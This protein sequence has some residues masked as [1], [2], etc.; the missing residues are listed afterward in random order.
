MSMKTAYLTHPDCLLH[1][2]GREHPES[3]DRLRA[4]ERHL[5]E[6]GV[7]PHLERHIAP[8]ATRRQLLR[9]HTEDYIDMV[10]SAPP[11]SGLV[12]LSFDAAMCP[13][14]LKAAL[15][16]AGAVTEAVD[17]VLFGD[18]DNAFCAIR[19]PGHHAESGFG[20]GFCIF[21]NVAVGAAHAMAEFGL[22]RVAILDF[23]VHHGNGTNEIFRRDER[24]L[25]CSTFQSPFYPYCGETSGNHHIINVPLPAET[26]SAAFRQAI[27]EHWIPAVEAFEPEMIFISAGF[28]AHRDDFMSNFLLTEAD[29]AWVTAEIMKLANKHAQG[30]VVSVLEGGYN[31]DSLGASVVAHVR[32][33]AGLATPEARTPRPKR[34]ITRELVDLLRLRYTLNWQ[35]M[36]GIAHWARVRRNGLR[37]AERTGARRDVV[38][39][40]AFL[41]D[42][43]RESD[44]DDPDHGRR[45]AELA[46]VLQGNFFLLDAAGLETL[47]LALMTHTHGEF[48]QDVTIQTCW[49]ANRLDLTRI[50]IQ[51]DPARLMTDAA[52]EI[53]LAGCATETIILQV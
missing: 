47:C 35:G 18:V 3:P 41:H 9:V 28:D 7:M 34:L 46:R 8:L 14:S 44:G 27:I 29:Y 17:R 38:E 49:D 37:L 43:C 48:T 22:K 5:A 21:N 1:T 31:A 45:A 6:S 39:L 26:D 13:D 16:A 10:E 15:R 25:L 11:E 23:D 53:A 36:H 32:E 19:P 50:G 33:L 40:F 20:M 24:V 12:F 30:R 2:L 51:P 4:I 52:R 42:S